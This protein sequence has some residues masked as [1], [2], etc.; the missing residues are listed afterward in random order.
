M[1][2]LAAARPSDRR[3]RRRA[4]A[5]LALWSTEARGR[6]LREAVGL[7]PATRALLVATEG[8]TDPVAYERVASQAPAQ[9]E[10]RCRA[11]AT[12]PKLD[13][14]CPAGARDGAPRPRAQAGMGSRASAP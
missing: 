2:E 11:E 13:R 5:A 9:Q 7:G 6:A 1:R 10:H 12:T 3:Q 4:V 14:S 8:V